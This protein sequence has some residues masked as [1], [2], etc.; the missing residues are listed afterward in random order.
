LPTFFVLTT[1]LAFLYFAREGVDMAVVEVGMGGRFD[2]TNLLVPR[3]SV[4][5]QIERDHCAHLG[6]KLGQ[7]AYEKAGI[8]KSGVPVVTAEWKEEPLEVI[9]GRVEAVGSRLIRVGE[10]V[11]TV[12]SDP[13]DFSYQGLSLS[14]EHLTCALRGAHQIQ[15]AATALAALEVLREQGLSLDERAIRSGLRRV[16]WEGRLQVVEEEPLLI[17]DGAHNPAAAR[18]LARALERL[19]VGRGRLILLLGILRDKEIPLIFEELVPLAQEVILTRPDYERAAPLS[20]LEEALQPY[21][22]SSRSSPQVPD[23]LELARSLATPRDLIC[24]TGSLSN[25]ASI[26]DPPSLTIRM[27]PIS[28]AGETCFKT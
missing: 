27:A 2:A 10:T 7:I 13:I 11:G 4:I 9:R 23:A 22:I 5:T 16:Q 14:L 6:E 24:V 3:V 20:L 1:A 12:G 8:V 19:R 21:G 25:T 17:L 18:V 28:A 26:S 15:N